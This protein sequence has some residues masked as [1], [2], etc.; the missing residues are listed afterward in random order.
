MFTLVSTAP[1]D[2]IGYFLLKCI[3]HAPFSCVHF[4]VS[5]CVAHHFL[6]METIWIDPLL[7]GHKAWRVMGCVL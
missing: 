2:L 1:K 5:D 3:E 7:L 4:T 6:I